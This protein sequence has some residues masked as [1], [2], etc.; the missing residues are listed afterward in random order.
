M[1]N[2]GVQPGP[3]HLKVSTLLPDLLEALLH[4]L[5]AGRRRGRV[6]EHERVGRGDGQASHGGKLHV[7]GRVQN[8]HLK[9]DSRESGV[10]LP[11]LL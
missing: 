9:R 6:D 1:Q 10:S 2:L 7:T 3:A 4:T 5:E 11:G 8:V